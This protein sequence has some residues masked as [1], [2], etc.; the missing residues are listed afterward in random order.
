MC[1]DL[2]LPEYAYPIPTGEAIDTLLRPADE[3]ERPRRSAG[4]AGATLLHVLA[5][6][7]AE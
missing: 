5:L 6:Q 4:A 2:M 1:G 3:L 7:L